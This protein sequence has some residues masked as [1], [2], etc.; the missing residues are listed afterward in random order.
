MRGPIEYVPTGEAAQVQFL[1]SASAEMHNSEYTG[2]EAGPNGS[3]RVP[4]I[5]FS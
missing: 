5:G 3:T 1:Q 4:A 2:T